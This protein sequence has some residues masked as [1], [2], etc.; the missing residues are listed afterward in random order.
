MYLLDTSLRDY[1]V[2]VLAMLSVRTV[3]KS[4]SHA[5]IVFCSIKRGG[6]VLATS[7]GYNSSPR[8]FLDAFTEFNRDGWIVE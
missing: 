7:R 5:R 1:D 2:T 6:Y 3:V 4:A 8:G